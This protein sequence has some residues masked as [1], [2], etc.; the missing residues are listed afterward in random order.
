MKLHQWQQEAIEFYYQ[1]NNK[2]LYQVVTGAGKTFFAITLLK[3]IQEKDPDTKWLIVV[4]KNVILETG[5]YTEL[6]SAGIPLY[7]IGMF[8]GEYKELAKIT[9]TNMQN[10]DRLPM[11]LFDG[12]I[13]DEIHNYGSERLIKYVNT[14][15]K[16][17]IGLSATIKRLDKRD[18]LITK[19]FDYN[20]FRY[21]AKEAMDDGILNKFDFCNVRIYMDNEDYQTYEQLDTEIKQISLAAGGIEKAIKKGGES[22]KAILGKINQ[23][24]QLVNNYKHKAEVIKKIITNHPDDKI[25]VFNQYNDQT[26]RLYWQLLDIDVHAKV[27]HSGIDKKKRFEILNEFKHGKIKVLLT[28]KVL[29]EGYNLKDID[30]GVIM[31][32]ESSDKQTVQRLGRILR[33]SMKKSKLY[34]MYCVNTIEEK[35]SNKRSKSFKQLCDQYEVFRYPSKT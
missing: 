21:A 11:E 27:F 18:M 7:D 35:H 14:E 15:F 2:A 6:K 9:L 33:K 22:A 17:K 1:N 23:R 28:T 30:V 5:W 34:Q 31:A 16:H 32:G 25:I 10:L 4:P 20:T 26:N 19:A 8:Y 12:I 13:F 29:D 3:Q 24:K